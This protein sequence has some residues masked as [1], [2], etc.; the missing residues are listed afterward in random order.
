ME[1][2]EYMDELEVEHRITEVEER[3]KSNTRRL[4]KLEPIVEEIHTMS[5]TLV[6]MAVEMKH[7][8]KNV[9]DIKDKVDFLEKAPAK[10]WND[11]Q[12][13]FF[14]AVLGA[15]GTA[16]AGGIIYVLTIIK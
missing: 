2:G 15:I 1:V 14:N 5:E 12:R 10:K 4:N 16:I 3:S 6:E 13:A 9:E 7:T 8:N 11:A